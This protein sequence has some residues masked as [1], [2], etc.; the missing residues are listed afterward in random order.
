MMHKLISQITWQFGKAFG[1]VK[2]DSNRL[3]TI[4]KFFFFIIKRN[5]ENSKNTLTHFQW[6]D[7]KKMF[8][9]KHFV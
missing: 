5:L 2:I 3:K 6:K 8:P 1:T 7:L 4:F 9:E